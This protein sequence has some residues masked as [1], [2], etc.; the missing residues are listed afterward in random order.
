MMLNSIFKKCLCN[1]VRM[2]PLRFVSKKPRF[3]EFSASGIIDTPRVTPPFTM[4]P[5]EFPYFED[6]KPL[7]LP[8]VKTRLLYVLNRYDKIA[9]TA[10]FDWKV[11]KNF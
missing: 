7:R 5:K 11:L 2:G 3:P 4:I 8:E 6:I 1:I 9:L 10:N